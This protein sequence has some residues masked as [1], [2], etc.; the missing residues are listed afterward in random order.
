MSGFMK[1]HTQWMSDEDDNAEVKGASV[2]AGNGEEG[3]HDIKNDEEI[4]AHNDADHYDC[5]QN[6]KDVDTE[7]V[8]LTS[9]VRDPHL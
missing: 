7:K 5:E 1:G 3:H 9:V 4:G 8:P 2:S 6:V